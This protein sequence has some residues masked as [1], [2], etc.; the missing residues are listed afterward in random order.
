M[1]HTNRWRAAS[2]E[3]RRLLEIL[4]YRHRIYYITWHPLWKN[5]YLFTFFLCCWFPCLKSPFTSIYFIT[6][7]MLLVLPNGTDEGRKMI[8]KAT[9][10]KSQR[11]WPRTGG[12]LRPAKAKL[13]ACAQ[14][15]SYMDVVWVWKVWQTGKRAGS[16]QTTNHFYHLC[17]NHVKRRIIKK[18]GDNSSWFIF[19]KDTAPIYTVDKGNSIKQQKCRYLDIKWRLSGFEVLVISHSCALNRVIIVTPVTLDLGWSGLHSHYFLKHTINHLTQK[20]V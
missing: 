9:R 8:L 16:P 7:T 1:L 5:A 4:A 11:T 2:H 19:C 10:N 12:G 14:K 6:R 3:W 18:E 15:S 17:N 20:T 13:D